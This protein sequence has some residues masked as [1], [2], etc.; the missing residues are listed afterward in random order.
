MAYFNSNKINLS[1]FGT[2]VTVPQNPTAKLM[3]YIDCI[4]EVLD[5]NDDYN[6]Q[7]IRDFKNYYNMNLDDKKLILKLCQL[8]HPKEFED[9]CISRVEDNYPLDGSNQFFSVNGANLNFV[10]TQSILIGGV[11]RYVRKIMLYK[12]KW[13]NYFF[14]NAY[15]D[16]F[17]EIQRTEN[18]QKLL[19][20][21]Q[22]Y[23]RRNYASNDSSCCC[24][25]L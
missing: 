24:N 5:F 10:A 7:R 13:L 23:S 20:Q 21:R 14:Y 1:T 4:C 22:T 15:N 8:L 2:T 6:I 3:Y 12:N 17:N 11:R 25:I 19:D 18:T 16:L 9:E